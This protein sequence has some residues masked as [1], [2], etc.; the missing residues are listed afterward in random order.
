M[1][2]VTCPN[3][4]CQTS[5][6]V[7][8][9]FLG[10]RV[11]CRAC[12][13]KFTVQAAPVEVPATQPEEIEP[14]SP[15]TRA[16]APLYLWIG[17]ICM[18]IASLLVAGCCLIGGGIY[19]FYHYGKDHKP[20]LYGGIEISSGDIR[21]VV[22]ECFADSE[23]GFDYRS[24]SPNPK[25]EDKIIKKRSD[26]LNAAGE[27][28]SNG[29]NNAVKEI[30][31]QY[32]AL[33]ANRAIP[34]ERIVVVA[35]PGVFKKMDEA[36]KKQNQ[37][38]LRDA[39]RA[40]T[41]G[42]TMTFVDEKKELALQIRSMLPDRFQKQTVVVDLGSSACRGGCLDTTNG[43]LLTFDTVGVKQVKEAVEKHAIANYNWKKGGNDDANRTN[44]IKACKESIDDAFS[45]PLIAA[46][47]KLNANQRE[48]L[49]RRRIEITGGV[50]YVLATY[51]SPAQ[52]EDIRRP[53]SADAIDSFYRDFRNVKDF[54]PFELPKDIDGKLKGKLIEDHDGI[55]R[56]DKLAPDSVIVGTEML[57]VLSRQLRFHDKDREVFFNNHGLDAVVLGLMREIWEKGKSKGTGREKRNK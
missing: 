48:L 6:Q 15:A 43:E 10:R 28:D 13:M 14:D 47:A 17:V 8:D 32:T 23:G 9:Q 26:L 37:D 7:P 5:C 42:H 19:Y 51:K 1:V 44:F 21:V 22:Y 50:P 12:K 35:G 36:A 31:E 39:V 16:G 33:K 57:N 56:N 29:F 40:A 30:A 34:P 4:T 20:D 55:V 49:G 41:G 27:F 11:V 25:V 52:R 46:L 3:S 38:K 24:L 18:G 53:L 2:S 45:T 54:P